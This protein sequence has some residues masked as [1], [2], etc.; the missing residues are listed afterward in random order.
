[1]T[2]WRAGW[3]YLIDSLEF[4]TAYCAVGVLTRGGVGGWTPID[5]VALVVCL[6]GVVLTCG[7]PSASGIRLVSQLYIAERVVGAI[8]V[9]VPLFDPPP[10]W[11][12]T[13]SA[14]L[15]L[16]TFERMKRRRVWPW[17]R[18]SCST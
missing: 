8:P 6:W 12:H 17:W 2:E 15:H 10:P 11:A 3:S 18:T 7:W 5:V 13:S 14:H 1:M 4:V 9:M 16:T